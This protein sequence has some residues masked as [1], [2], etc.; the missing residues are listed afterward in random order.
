MIENLSGQQPKKRGA[1]YLDEKAEARALEKLERP[2]ARALFRFLIQTGMRISEALTVRTE[3]VERGST[4][5]RGKGGKVR[6]VY[7]R[8]ALQEEMRQYLLERK[9][10]SDQDGALLFP[11]S[12]YTAHRLL[13]EADVYPHLLRHTYLTRKL[14]ETGDIRLVQE[15]AGH[16]DI[17]TTSKY[18]HFTEQEIKAA[19]TEPR[20]W[21]E[22]LATMRPDR[23]QKRACKAPERSFDPNPAHKRF[24]VYGAKGSGKT[25]MILNTWSQAHRVEWKT[26]GQTTK[27]IDALKKEGQ[28]NEG[29][30]LVIEFGTPTPTKM[31]YA[32]DLELSPDCTLVVEFRT[33]H[34]RDEQNLLSTLFEFQPLVADDMNPAEAR[35]YL[36]H[37]CS[38]SSAQY[39]QVKELLDVSTNPL[40][41][42]ENIN[43]RRSEIKMSGVPI[44]FGWLFI[45]LALLLIVDRYVSMGRESYAIVTCLYTLTGV[46]RR[47]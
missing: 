34:G 24:V 46:I 42:R 4:T 44:T 26:K 10:R 22:R 6:T 13:N 17:R 38:T 11:F 30:P 31:T 12:R 25:H 43:R 41:L 23:R 1:G 5:I 9:V 18:T 32:E 33:R 3:D 15:I 37:L 36:R 47:L 39:S 40:F 19:M 8:R 20:T 27:A 35:Q 29:R 7:Y 2:E 21:R 28:L 45:C 16:K 14:K